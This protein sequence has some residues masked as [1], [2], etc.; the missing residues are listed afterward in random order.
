MSTTH[1]RLLSQWNKSGLLYQ[2]RN[3][4]KFI[5]CWVCF[6]HL[7]ADKISISTMLVLTSCNMTNAIY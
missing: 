1:Q 3:A 4:N 2:A 6:C 5:S 7:R